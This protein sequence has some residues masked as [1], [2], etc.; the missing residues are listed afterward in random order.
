[1]AKPCAPVYDCDRVRDHELDPV[2]DAYKQAEETMAR[3][4]R[5]LIARAS[6]H[7]AE[8]RLKKRLAEFAAQSFVDDTY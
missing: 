5:V 8:E 7:R 1:M 4:R 2:Y 6:Y 3:C